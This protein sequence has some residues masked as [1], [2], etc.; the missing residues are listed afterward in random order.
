ME[1]T[2][3]ILSSQ[4]GSSEFSF[5]KEDI[6]TLYKKKG[7]EKNIEI[8]VTTHQNHAIE[9]TKNFIRK[10]D[11]KKSII[12]CGGDGSLNEVAGAIYPSDTALGLI[13]MGTGN[14][15]SKNLNY[16]NFTLEKTLKRTISPIDL[17]EVN[18]K[19]C[20]NVTSLGFD[21][22]VLSNAYYFLEKKPSLGKK[23]YI[24]S[25]I[26]SLKNIDYEDLEI[27]LET[28]D[29]KTIHIKGEYLL[30]A[31]C[32]GGYY[33]SGFNPAPMAKIDDGI[34]N[35]VLAKKI[36]LIRLLPLILKYRKGK[37]EDSPYL[38]H[39]KVKSGIIKSKTPFKAN[40]DGE[41]FTSKEIT[42]K[43][44]PQALKWVYFDE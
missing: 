24:K 13:P 3:F 9:A 1:K 23:A 31:L 16:K 7:L 32:N 37:L 2:L 29:S 12:V 21:T 44:L 30:L 34:L 15:F 17:I 38:D 22:E 36:S 5:T 8:V 28:I 35:L 10:D 40:I 33:G 20:V 42:F 19:I 18:G 11:E 6:Y 27:E 43:I 25:V 41:I 26:Y 39:Y 14:D 4:A